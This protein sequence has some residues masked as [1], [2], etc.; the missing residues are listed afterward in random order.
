MHRVRGRIEKIFGTWK[1]PYGL[2][3]MRWR[4]LPKAAAQVRLTAIG[5]NLKRTMNILAAS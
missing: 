4:G 2:R 1:R 3:L 5:Y